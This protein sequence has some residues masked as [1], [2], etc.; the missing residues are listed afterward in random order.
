[1]AIKGQFLKYHA[2]PTKSEN[3]CQKAYMDSQTQNRNQPIT[4]TQI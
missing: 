3:L 2:K 4:H 1:M